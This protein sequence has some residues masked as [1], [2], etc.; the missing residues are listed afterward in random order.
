MTETTMERDL[1]PRGGWLK[2]YLLPFAILVGAVLV[3]VAL[4]RSKPR[5]RRTPPAPSAKLVEVEPIRLGDRAIAI[6]VMGTVMPAHEIALTPR[7]SGQIVDTSPEFAPGGFFR[8]GEVMVRIDPSDYALL[9]Q[10]RESALAQAES[11]HQLEMGQQTIALREYELLREMVAEEDRDLVLRQPQLQSAEAN[12][13]A[14]R[15][16]LE[17]ARLD[18]ERTQVRAP[19]NAVLSAQMADVGGQVSPA[20]PLGQ[21][22]D[23]DLFWVEVSV[24]VD[25]LRWIAIPRRAEEKGARARIYSESAWGEGVFR[26]GVVIRLRPGLEAQ[27]RMARLL[28]EV[29]DPLARRPEHAEAPRMILSTYVRVEIEGATL[30]DVATISRS[31]LRDGDRV[32]LM[33]GDGRLEIRPVE[34]IFRGSEAVFVR[35]VGPGERLVT[36]DLSAPVEGM[37]L[38]LQND[39]ET[40]VPVHKEGAS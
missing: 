10:Q 35:G 11:V 37:P 22:V 27:G 19:F 31:A 2:R 24:P 40:A 21:L 3:G 28:I 6:E 14:A 15:A 29:P 26:S 34:V 36:T 8:K 12:V 9:V 7:V 4:M 18:L 13:A 32:Y 1:T 30:Q 5:A 16:A 39:G 17:D 23:M 25:Q 33:D 38:R 20:S